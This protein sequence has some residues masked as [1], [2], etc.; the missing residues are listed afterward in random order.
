MSNQFS[1]K[2]WP[3]VVIMTGSVLPAAAFYELARAMPCLCDVVVHSAGIV[4]VVLRQFCR[5]VGIEVPLSTCLW[6]GLKAFEVLLQIG[7][8][9]RPLIC[10]AII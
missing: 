2:Y 10:V 6:D 8:A 7:E 5:V 4:A 9:V 3:A 1:V